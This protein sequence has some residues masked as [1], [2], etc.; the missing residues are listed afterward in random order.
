[1]HASIRL[2]SAPATRCLDSGILTSSAN[3]RLEYLYS[4]EFAALQTLCAHAVFES[5]ISVEREIHNGAEVMGKLPCA[6]IGRLVP[7]LR[8][9]LSEYLPR[10]P[11]QTSRPNP[12]QFLLQQHDNV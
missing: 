5:D 10:I 6:F 3:P 4:H 9:S 1:M 12:C 8:S 11:L 2:H 7:K